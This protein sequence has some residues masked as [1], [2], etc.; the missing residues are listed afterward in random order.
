MTQTITKVAEES[1]RGSLYLFSGTALAT[2]TMAVASIL[3]GRLLGPELYGQYTIALTIPQFLFIIVDLGINQ[4]VTKFT[5]T[6]T[7]KGETAKAVNTSKLK[8]NT[9]QIR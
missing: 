6:Y 9:R 1:T 7:A 4:G 3:I 5:A 2:V 8:M